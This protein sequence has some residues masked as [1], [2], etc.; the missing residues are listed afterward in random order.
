M[1]WDP[2]GES[3]IKVR[4]ATEEIVEGLIKSIEQGVVQELSR[5]EYW[6]KKSERV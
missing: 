1:E 4:P 2:R 3:L 6:L 5:K